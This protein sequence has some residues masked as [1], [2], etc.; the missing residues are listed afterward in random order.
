MAS[1]GSGADATVLR[2][3]MAIVKPISAI[4][5][6]TTERPSPQSTPRGTL[7]TGLTAS[8][9]MSA[10]SSNPTRVKTPSR[11]ASAKAYQVGLW[12]ADVV[13][14]RMPAPYGEGLACTPH[15][16]NSS[17]PNTTVPMISV[18]TATLLTR[19]ATWMLMMLITTGSSIRMIATVSTRR[20]L[21]LLT[22]NSLS[23]SG[24]ATSSMIAPPPTAM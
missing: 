20:G 1:S 3:G 22:L 10:A 14:N 21:G 15:S 4:M 24:D 7:R 12:K 13:L 5:P 11:L 8:S 23:S 6:R 9:D 2:S 19:A 17:T 18:N 16:T